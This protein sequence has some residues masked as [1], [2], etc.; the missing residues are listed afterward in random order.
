MPSY[1]VEL[2]R[3]ISNAGIPRLVAGPRG[4][5]PRTVVW[6]GVLVIAI[7]WTVAAASVRSIQATDVTVIPNVE[8]TGA[9]DEIAMVRWSA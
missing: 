7:A 4:S 6:F 5:G 9:P 8:V 2:S 3:P 1:V